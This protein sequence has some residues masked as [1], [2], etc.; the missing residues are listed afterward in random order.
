MSRSRKKNPITGIA[1]C[2]SEKSDKKEWHSRMRQMEKCRLRTN[3]ESV[4]TV[5]KDAS[6][7]WAM[8]KDGKRYMP[9]WAEV[10]RK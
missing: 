4:A 5:E 9:Q 3:P 10:Y 6:N 8:G 1:I 7:P 2:A